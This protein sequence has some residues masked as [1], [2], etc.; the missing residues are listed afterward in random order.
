MYKKQGRR[1]GPGN[2][3]KLT[4]IQ[5]LHV[6]LGIGPLATCTDTSTIV[7]LLFSHLQDLFVILITVFSYLYASLLMSIYSVRWSRLAGIDA[8]AGG[9]NAA[10]GV[11]T[12]SLGNFW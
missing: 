7:M 8:D 11:T 12:V 10:T 2:E 9:I 1:G 3:T 4:I 6:T 5:K